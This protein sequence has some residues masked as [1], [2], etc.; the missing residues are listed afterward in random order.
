[1]M[2]SGILINLEMPDVLMCVLN[3]CLSF[4][5]S[6]HMFAKK[7]YD[8]HCAEWTTID[9]NKFDLQSECKS[10]VSNLSEK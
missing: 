10:V 9:A 6:S 1:M 5:A 3:N 2:V 7:N 4:M 8:I